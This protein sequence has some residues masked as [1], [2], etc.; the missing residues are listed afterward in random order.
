MPSQNYIVDRGRAPRAVTAQESDDYMN[1]GFMNW[2]GKY[3]PYGIMAGIAAPHLAA[4]LTP[5]FA[6][7]GAAAGGAG[8]A[9]GT[10]AATT[11]AGVGAA[12]SGFWSPTTI[13]LLNAGIGTGTQLIGAKMQSNAANR[14]AQ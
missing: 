1:K 7:G 4:L 9:T 10:T 11:A 8:A 12:A 5:A 13:G 6:G 14:A 3:A 2:L